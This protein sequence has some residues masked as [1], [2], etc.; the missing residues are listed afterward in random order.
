MSLNSLANILGGNYAGSSS[1]PVD[2]RYVLKTGDTMTGNLVFSDAGEGLT[3]PGGATFRGTA[4][5]IDAVASGTNQNITL[6]PSGSGDVVIGPSAQLLINQSN[7]TTSATGLGVGTDI[8][9]YR[10]STREL[11]FD[12]IGGASTILRWRENGTG[13]GSIESAAGLFQ[14]GTSGATS[15]RL[16]TNNTVALTLDA[17]QNAT[18]V[19]YV[20]GNKRLIT[21][22]NTT[23]NTLNATTNNSVVF[24]NE[25]ASALNV[26][27]LPTAAANLT[28]TFYVQDA[29]GIQIVAS[30]GDTIRL[31][32]SVTAAAGSVSST[33]VGSSLTLVAIN[34]TEW[35]ASCIV[36]TWA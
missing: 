3:L 27:N 21:P 31:S 22:F 9:L 20:I 23:P 17:S 7:G 2:G 25:G 10:L 8:G 32:G 36:G 1:G 6:T 24:T 34:A 16:F 19:G 4:G 5:S 11:A 29:D 33:T 15:F 18:F 30:A 13:I 12:G 26:I 14:I 35:V 28:Y